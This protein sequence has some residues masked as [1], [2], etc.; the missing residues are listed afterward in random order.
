MSYNRVGQ[1]VVNP[2]TS[3][4]S[5]FYASAVTASVFI[6]GLLRALWAFRVMVAA[7]RTLHRNMLHAVISAPILFFDSNPIGK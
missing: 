1:T 5:L 6:S 7:S 3:H 4:P 2:E